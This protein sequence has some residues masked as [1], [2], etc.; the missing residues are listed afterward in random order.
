M[1]LKNNLDCKI[2]VTGASGFLGSHLCEYLVKNKF[3]V[4]GLVRKI[5]NLHLNENGKILLKNKLKIIEGDLK[6]PNSLKVL[7]E[8]FNYIFHL[9]GIARP[10]SILEQEYF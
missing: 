3:N 10:E 5:S 8:E 2:L 1:N 6:I 7:E 4:T 9:G